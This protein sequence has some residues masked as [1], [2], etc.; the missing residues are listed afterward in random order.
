MIIYFSWCT[1][2][3]SLKSVKQRD[4]K[5]L[6][7]Q[8]IHMSNLTPWPLNLKIN[9]GHLLFMM[10]WSTKFEVCQAKV[11]QDIEKSVYSNVQFYPLT[12][13]LLT[14][15]QLWSSF[16]HDVLVYKVWKSVKERDLKTLSSQYIH[17]LYLQLEWKNLIGWWEN[18]KISLWPVF[19]SH[20][21]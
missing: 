7:S 21:H 19:V 11:F 10:Y 9:C 13:D 15:N 4:L 8:Y 5:I 14:S 1:R 16:F 17:L 12:F 20:D 3:Q 2:L 6:S 18:I